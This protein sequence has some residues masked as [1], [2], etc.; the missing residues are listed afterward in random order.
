MAKV[1]LNI[2]VDHTKKDEVLFKAIRPLYENFR[3]HMVVL[4]RK[5]AG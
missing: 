3:H 1:F 4:F 2:A 5:G